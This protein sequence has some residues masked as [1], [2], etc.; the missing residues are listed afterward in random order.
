MT[1]VIDGMA[2]TATN[3]TANFV[4]GVSSDPSQSFKVDGTDASLNLLSFDITNGPH[5]LITTGIYTI[6]PDNASAADYVV[7]LGTQTWIAASDTGSGSVTLTT[8]S[9]AAKTASGTFSFVL[10]NN[11][12]T[13]LVTTGVFNV[14]FP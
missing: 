7:P 14:T 4:G 10:K 3:V 1:A 5:S 8:F 9:T 13:K 2:W 12:S 11:T 6:G